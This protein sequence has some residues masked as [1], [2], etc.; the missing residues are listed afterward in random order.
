MLTLSDS[1]QIFNLSRR[2]T[3]MISITF[4]TVSISFSLLT[5]K[6]LRYVKKH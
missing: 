4:L 6:K 3:K 1:Q 5:S 2:L